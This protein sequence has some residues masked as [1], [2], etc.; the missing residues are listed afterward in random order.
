MPRTIQIRN[1][2]DDVYLALS[3]RAAA[4]GLTVPGLLR[5]EAGRLADRPLVGEWLEN[6]RRSPSGIT[7]I[8]VLEALDEHRGAWSNP[9]R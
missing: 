7:R 4:V 9:S 6:T 2:D 5:R 8:E 3:K 1:L